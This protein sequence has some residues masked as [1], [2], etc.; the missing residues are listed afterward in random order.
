MLDHFDALVKFTSVV[1]APIDNT[2]AE[3]VLKLVVLS[4]KNSLFF[5][6]A[7]GAKI[8]DRLAGLVETCRLAGVAAYDYLL[9]LVRNADTVRASPSEWLPWT[10]PHQGRTAKAA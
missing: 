5:K 8:G 7:N 1:G 6:N 2:P 4:R 10:Y 3:R 9:A